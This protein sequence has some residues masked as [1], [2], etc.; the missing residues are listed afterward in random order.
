MFYIKKFLINS[1]IGKV[2]SSRSSLVRDISEPDRYLFAPLAEHRH[3]AN[4]FNTLEWQK[5]TRSILYLIVSLMVLK[6]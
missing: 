4:N 3:N 5:Q 2:S 1:I 6:V